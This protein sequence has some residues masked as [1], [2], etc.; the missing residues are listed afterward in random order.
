MKRDFALRS[1]GLLAILSLPLTISASPVELVPPGLQAG[2][3]YRLV[4]VTSSVTAATSSDI[5]YYDN[6]VNNA[7]NASGSLLQP[8]GATWQA[9]AS[10][11]AVSAADHIGTFS[12]P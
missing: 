6:F 3:Q 10:T 4:F 1:A 12:V 2:D 11:E 7:A 9:I 5:S 8:L